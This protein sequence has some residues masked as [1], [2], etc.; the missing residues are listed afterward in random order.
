[1]GWSGTMK[2]KPNATKPKK[3]TKRKKKLKPKKINKSVVI[4]P[5]QVK[6]DVDKKIHPDWS[7]GLVKLGDRKVTNR[8]CLKAVIHGQITTR[9]T[10]I[11]LEAHELYKGNN[12]LSSDL[13]N[14]LESELIPE[15]IPVILLGFEEGIST[16]A[17]D[18]PDDAEVYIKECFVLD[19]EASEDADTNLADPV[20]TLRKFETQLR[21][22]KN[23]KK[24]TLG[25]DTFTDYNKHRNDE[26]YLQL[27]LDP[28]KDKI[29]PNQWGP[30]N[31]KM[32][33]DLIFMRKLHMHVI[34]SA[35]DKPDWESAWKPGETWAPDVWDQ[36]LQKFDLVLRT[37]Y[38][39]PPLVDEEKWWIEFEKCRMARKKNPVDMSN[40]E[41]GTFVDIIERIKYNL[42]AKR[43]AKS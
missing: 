18:Y 4:K 42:G 7:D 35:Q 21:K 27:G 13:Q 3:T 23:L 11:M 15:G 22:L 30:R 17:D 2:K 36:A 41:M 10:S 37:K 34:C 16:L 43:N 32:Y 24:G 40:I 26:L 8:G 14:A 29:Q 38:L 19:E 25:V 9:K 1:M 28:R 33:G 5:E 12:Q 6:E 31:R 20:A 39:S